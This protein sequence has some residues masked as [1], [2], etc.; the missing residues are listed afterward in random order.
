M[1]LSDEQRETLA[2][3]FS[4]KPVIAVYVFG[5]YARGDADHESDVDLI[6]V[7][8]FDASAPMSALRY[9]KDL[10]VLLSVRTDVYQDHRILKYARENILRERC[11]VYVRK[12]L[13]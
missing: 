9:K 8:D 7:R 2:K 4:S 1:Q 6:V 5:S 10:D 13:A 11:L 12:P 3:Y